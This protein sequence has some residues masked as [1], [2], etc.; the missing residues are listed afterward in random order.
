MVMVNITLK[1]KKELC[2]E[3]SPIVRITWAEVLHKWTISYVMA[4]ILHCLRL[5]A[6]ACTSSVKFYG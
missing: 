3:S 1:K 2:H 6:I 4:L 5:F